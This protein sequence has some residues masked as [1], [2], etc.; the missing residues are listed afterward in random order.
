MKDLTEGPISKHLFEMALPMA[1]GM[2]FQTLYFLVDLYFVGRLGDA[3]IAGV[4]AA[5]TITFLVMAATQV[6]AVGSVALISQAVGRK[7][8]P[9]ANR[10]F[11]QTMVMSAACVVASLLAGYAGAAAYARATTADAAAA[12]ASLEYLRW[13]L[14]AMGLQFVVAALSSALRGTGIV[15]P[16]IATQMFTVVLNVL[17]A[18]VLIGGWG[19]GHPLGV[20]GAGLASSI[21]VGVGTLLLVG[22]FARLE[23]Y[24]QLAPRTWA[25]QFTQWRR[26]CVVGL[27]A[28]GEFL[29]LFMISAV[30]YWAVRPFGAH[31]QA[32]FGVGMRVMQAIFLPAMAVGFSVAPIVGQNFGAGRPERVREAFR[33]GA[34]IGAAAMLVSMTL[35]LWNPAAL[36]AP[37]VPEPAAIAVGAQYLRYVAWNFVAVGFVFTCSGFLQGLGKTLPSLWS[38]GSRVLTFTVPVLWLSHR[39]GFKLTD[40]W[41]TSITSVTLQALI[42]AWLVRRQMRISLAGAATPGG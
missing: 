4:G 34:L 28:G 9:D 32:G 38:S 24:V 36:V 3:A 29:I 30:I 17:L 26:I 20:A 11:N 21:A 18:P 6:L 27:P 16:A 19:T 35:C 8:Q 22:Y 31:S 10:L 12:A 41:I 15:K 2:L 25:P 37:F 14:P 42:S 7:D 13:Y 40:I 23:H 5:G 39:P 33:T 1:I